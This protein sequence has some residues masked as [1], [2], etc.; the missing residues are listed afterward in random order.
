MNIIKNIGTLSTVAL[1]LA[2]AMASGGSLAQTGKAGPNA[3]PF[4]LEI[5]RANCDEAQ[6]KLG[7]AS[8]KVLGGGDLWLDAKSPS[9]LYPGANK[10][11]LRCS[12]NQVI[13]LQI[14]IPK[15]GL[16]NEEAQEAFAQLKKKYKLVQGRA[17]PSLGDGYA[18]F[19]AASSV[20]EQSAPT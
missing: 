18:R 14:T 16:G 2:S 15:A 11:G 3:A 7:E 9:T 20:I 17:M 10:I 12:N 1:L 6:S 19:V 5:G 13:A 8:K 4:G